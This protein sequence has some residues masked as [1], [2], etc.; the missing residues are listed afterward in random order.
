[1]TQQ[2]F[3]D[4]E[5]I[6]NMEPSEGDHQHSI[7]LSP[8]AIPRKVTAKNDQKPNNLQIQFDYDGQEAGTA[9][10]ALDDRDDPAILVQ[11]AKYT[12]KVL[13][14]QA[15]PFSGRV[16]LTQLAERFRQAADRL[17]GEGPAR[18]L[19]YLMIAAILERFTGKLT[20]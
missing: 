20:S 10:Q 1:M 17:Q 15:T 12:Q 4:P 6:A 5:E 18:R 3:L 7:W 13:E 16:D 2:I 9:F 19:S 11:T 8:F 14:I